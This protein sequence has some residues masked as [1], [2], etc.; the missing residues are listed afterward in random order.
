MYVIILPISVFWLCCS[1]TSWI[2]REGNNIP[3]H[4]FKAGYEKDGSPLYIAR[5]RM[6]DGVMTPGKCGPGVKGAHFPYGGKEVIIEHH[7]EVF[8]PASNEEPASQSSR[9]ATSLQ[10]L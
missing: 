6:V 4:A 9:M 7:Y 8:V 3:L 5:A 2:K 10:M 1:M